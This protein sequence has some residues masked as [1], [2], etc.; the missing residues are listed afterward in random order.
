MQFR[1]IPYQLK[2]KYPFRIAHGER[3]HTNVVYVLLQHNHFTAYGEAALPPY[4]P[5]TQDSV[6]AFVHDFANAVGEFGI[7]D[8]LNEL[9]HF[10]TGNMAARAAIDM[11]LWNLKSQIENKSIAQLLGV[12]DAPM[13]LNTYTIGVCSPNEM[14]LKVDDANAFGFQIFK[15][16]LDGKSDEEM[17]AEFRKLTDLPFAVDVN[18][19]WKS[20]AEATSKIHWLKQQGCVLVEQ[21]LLTAMNEEMKQLK[22]ITP[23]PL[24]ADESCQTV[25]DL[26]KLRDCYHGVNIKLMKCGGITPAYEMLKAAKQMGFKVLIG[27]M[28]E[29]SVGCHAAAQLAMLADYTDLDGPYLISNDCFSGVGMKDGSL[30]TDI[31]LQKFS[32]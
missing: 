2:F 12:P 9:R 13:P 26:E 6:I 20:T 1:C 8:C 32:F 16:K 15:L 29:S 10:R 11:A 21:P 3:T 4:L 25:D 18:Q 30:L 17:V 27:C 7:D 31:L 19:G 14:K 23:L 22:A 5:E 28:S 24:Y